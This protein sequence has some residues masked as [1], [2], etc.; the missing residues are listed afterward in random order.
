MVCYGLLLAGCC[1]LLSDCWIEFEFGNDCGLAVIGYVLWL[2]A[3]LG[4][5][6]VCCVYLVVFMTGCAFRY[7]VCW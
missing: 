4:L 7:F 6:L 1:L 5:G 3:L 2:F